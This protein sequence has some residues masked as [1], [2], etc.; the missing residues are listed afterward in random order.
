M[1]IKAFV[2]N[3]GLYNESQL[4]GEW[5]TFPI[6]EDEQEE[7]FKRIGIDE[8]H[9]EYFMTDYESELDLF[10]MFGEY[11]SIEKLNELAEEVESLDSY[12]EEIIEALISEGGY[13]F[14]QAMSAKDDVI[15]YSGC[16][17]MT[18][19]AEQYANET[20]L[21][22]S[23]PENLRY[24]FDFEAFGRDMSFDGEYHFHN[25]NCYQVI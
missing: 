9:E 16:S 21:L 12:E 1:K 15:V 3:L 18:E 4:V 20:G 25:G 24:Y 11:V 23:I 2:T 6:D 10:H 8:E 7:L 22:D 13:S 19:V 14:E 17:D 5:V